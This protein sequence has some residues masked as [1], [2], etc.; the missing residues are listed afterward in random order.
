M[1]FETHRLNVSQRKNSKNSSCR[2]NG[3][4]F[5]LLSTFSNKVVSRRGETRYAASHLSVTRRQQTIIDE[6]VRMV[7]V[8]VAHGWLWRSSARNFSGHTAAGSDTYLLS[9][10][11]CANHVARITIFGWAAVIEVKMSTAGQGELPMY[12]DT[13]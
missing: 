9:L 5:S 3:G 2:T 13:T 12:I 6:C 4:A 8:G 11:S 1:L 10:D 7:K